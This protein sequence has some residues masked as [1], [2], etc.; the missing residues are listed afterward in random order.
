MTST[1]KSRVLLVDDDPDLRR[2]LARMLRTDGYE[3]REALNGREALQL[4]IDNHDFVPVVI[5]SDHDMPLMNGR[6]LHQQLRL[7]FP[8]LEPRFILM[9]GNDKVARYAK[10]VC[11]P[12]LSK[13]FSTEALSAAI[14]SVL[15]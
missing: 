4:L 13:P 3:V 1:P 15:P 10:D 7:T 8:E 11:I 2:A 6:E 14:K 9:S 12:F 5:L